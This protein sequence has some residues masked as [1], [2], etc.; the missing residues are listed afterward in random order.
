MLPLMKF[1]VLA[2]RQL[3]K[4][5]AN[6]IKRRCLSNPRFRAGCISFAQYAFSH[7]LSLAGRPCARA[8]FFFLSHSLPSPPTL[9][10][11]SSRSF[12]LAHDTQ[13]S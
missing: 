2:M 3:S 8:L 9:A 6:A 13:K 10:L 1:G 7:L 5:I 4:P 12:P 11:A